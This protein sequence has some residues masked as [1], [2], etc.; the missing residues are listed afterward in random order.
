MTRRRLRGVLAEAEFDV[1]VTTG[2]AAELADA[3]TVGR[4]DIVVVSWELATD[5]ESA[6]LQLLR[7]RLPKPNAVVVC[8]NS[9]P[10]TVRKAL[11]AGADGYVCEADVE[12]ALAEAVQAVRA[13]QVCLPGEMREALG[14]PAFS[15]REKQ[16]LQLVAHGFTNAEI[17][18]RLY[19][20]ESTVKSHLSSTF[21]KLGVGSRKDAAAIVLDP[22]HGLNLEILGGAPQTSAL[23]TTPSH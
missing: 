19:L 3:C 7:T 2:T 12:S 6:E 8:P 17:A 11:A 5:D 20:A 10:R 16:V 18:A 15:F 22:N 21:R 14:R 23:E 13:G 1:V 4:V 9:D